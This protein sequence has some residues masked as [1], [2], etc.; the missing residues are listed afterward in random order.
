M[1]LIVLCAMV[2]LVAR[3][4]KISRQIARIYEDLTAEPEKL[5]E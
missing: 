1:N 5:E 3:V 4:R 2:Y